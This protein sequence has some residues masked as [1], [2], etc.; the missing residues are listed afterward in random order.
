MFANTESK[1][2]TVGL[3]GGIGS[4]KSFV[5]DMFAARGA[6]IIDTD[7]LAHQLTAPQGKAIPAIAQQ[8]GS[9]FLT[10]EGAMNRA[11]MR[12]HVFADTSAKKK[13]EAILHPLIRDC[14]EEAARQASGNYP[15]F[16]VPLLVESGTWKDRVSRVLVVDC[17]EEL[18]IRRVM[19]R[20]D[21]SEQQVRSIMAMQATRDARLAAA[22]D[23]IVND[24]DPA[25]L[26]PQVDRLHALYLSFAEK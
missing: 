2:F 7:A 16:V 13:L 22:D 26:A 8:F 11:K 9:D 24:A 5:A 15:I 23:V 10:P 21:F 20:N 1:R 4:G 14:A 18:Q 12:E 6:S 19:Q 3:T 25:A 17:P